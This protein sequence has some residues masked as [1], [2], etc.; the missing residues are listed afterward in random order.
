MHVHTYTHGVAANAALHV[1]TAVPDVWHTY[2]KNSGSVRSPLPKFSPA[3]V[4]VRV[5]EAARGTC[6]VTRGAT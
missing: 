4:F 5:R 2:P 3:L 6:H 1:S